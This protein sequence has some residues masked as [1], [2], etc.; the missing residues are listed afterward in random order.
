MAVE[1]RLE[2]VGEIADRIDVAHFAVGDEAGEHRPVFGSDLMT[3]EESVLPGQ[4]DFSDLIFDRVGVQLKAAVLQAERGTTVAFRRQTSPM[5]QG[6][7]AAKLV[8]AI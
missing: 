1:Q 2:C 4:C 5:R 3:C 8:T 7:C 6:G